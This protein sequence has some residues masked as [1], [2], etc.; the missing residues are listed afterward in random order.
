MIVRVKDDRGHVPIYEH[1]EL[2]FAREI[3]PTEGT[4]LDLVVAT[5]LNAEAEGLP[6]IDYRSH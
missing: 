5:V 2:G 1:S 4:A 3:T 6:L